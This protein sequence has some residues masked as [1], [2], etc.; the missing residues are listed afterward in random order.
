MWLDEMSFILAIV[1][2]F[3]YISIHIF[4]IAIWK[5]REI[6]WATCGNGAVGSEWLFAV[7]LQM[8]CAPKTPYIESSCLDLHFH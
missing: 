6:Q 5:M 1:M 7:C 4:S 3:F 2:L 8:L